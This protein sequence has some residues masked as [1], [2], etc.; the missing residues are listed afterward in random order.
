MIGKKLIKR[1]YRKKIILKKLKYKSYYRCKS[2]TWKKS[3]K[4]LKSKFRKIL[5]FVCSK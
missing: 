1:H 2:Y 3:V 5:R 4:I